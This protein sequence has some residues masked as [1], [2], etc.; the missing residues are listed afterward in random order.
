[1]PKRRNSNRSFLVFRV[2]ARNRF[3]IKA[4]LILFAI[5]LMAGSYL[6]WQIAISS[7][8]AVNTTAVL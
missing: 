2:S 7:D 3:W 6:G 5:A 8:E 1:M 4:I